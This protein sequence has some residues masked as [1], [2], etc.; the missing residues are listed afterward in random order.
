ML[1][2]DF[3]PTMRKSAFISVTQ[4]SINFSQIYL[5]LAGVY[6]IFISRTCQF[7]FQFHTLGLRLKTSENRPW[8]LHPILVHQPT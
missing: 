8:V 5:G 7:L 3:R 4:T 2:N 6:D 1:D